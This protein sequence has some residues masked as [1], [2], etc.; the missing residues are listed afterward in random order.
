MTNMHRPLGWILDIIYKWVGHHTSVTPAA[1]K[2]G[3]KLK[4]TLGYTAG[5]RLAWVM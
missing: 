2:W 4:V 1:G 3:K 5:L